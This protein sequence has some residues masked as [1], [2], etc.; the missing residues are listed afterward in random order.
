MKQYYPV[1]LDLTD[2][3]CVI[4]GGGEVAQRKAER[5]I[6]CGAHVTVVSPAL[7]PLL[8]DRKKERR[9]DH[10]DTAYQKKALQGAFMVIGATD[11][12]DVNAQVSRDALTLGIL[13]NIVDDPD[14]C[15]FILPSLVQQGDLS[16]AVSTG[17]K[18]PALARKIRQELQKQYGPEYESL[19]KIMGSL[20]KKILAQGHASE[21]N[22]AVFEALVRSDM[23]QAIRDGNRG[24]VK[25]IIHEISG[26]EM[27]VSL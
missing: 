16:I 26:I 27:D 5:L 23:L 11:C 21:A 17:G 13:V 3:R 6:E 24:L 7:T 18:S 9:I 12:D 19:L 25:K 10:I 20:R 22:R 14:R 8:E 15:N 2:K 4:I 1:S